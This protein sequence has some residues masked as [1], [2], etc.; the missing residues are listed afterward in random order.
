[1]LEHGKPL[2]FGKQRDK[3]II[4]RGH[5]LD[6]VQLGNGVSES[7]LVVHDEGDTALAFLLSLMMPP[8]FPTPIGIF[9]AV[10]RP[11]Y[12]AILAE[13]IDRAKQRQ[14]EGNLEALL[15]GGDT[16]TVT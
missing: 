16:W 14:G 11:T 5:A 8:K 10:E 15:N 9:R 6:V 4:M 1:M 3:G 12:E 7:D 2:V 13:Q